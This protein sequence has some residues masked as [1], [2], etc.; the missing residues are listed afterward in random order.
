L[1]RARGDLVAGRP[2]GCRCRDRPELAG[3]LPSRDLVG[4]SRAAARH[5]DRL[6]R[7][8]GVEDAGAVPAPCRLPGHR[9][10]G[11]GHP[12]AGARRRAGRYVRE[13]ARRG[14]RCAPV[15]AMGLFACGAAATDG[16]L[17]RASI[18]RRRSAARQPR[19]SRVLH[20]LSAPH[21]GRLPRAVGR[22][23]R[24]RARPVVRAR[25]APLRH[26][27]RS[28]VHGG[29]RSRADA[30]GRDPHARARSAFRV[31]DADRSARSRAPRR[32]SF[33]RIAR[34]ELR[35]RVRVGRHPEE[36]RPPADAGG[37][38]AADHP[39]L[40]RAG[41]RHRGVIRA[42]VSARHVGI[43]RRDHRLLDRSR[44]HGG[45]VQ[46]ADAVSRDAA[47]EPAR[48]ARLRAGLGE[49]RRVHAHLRASV[50][51][52]RGAALPARRRLQPVLRPPV[53]AGGLD[54]R[55]GGA[56]APGGAAHGRARGAA[57]RAR[58]TVDHAEG[59]HMLTA[60][61]RY[62]PRTIPETDAIVAH[63]R[64][65]GTLIQGPDI[66][67]FER[68][69]AD[70]LGVRDVITTSYGRMAFYY[71]L[72]AFGFPAGAEVIV[73]ALTFWVIPEMV[74][75]AGLTP[76]PADVDP[77][78]FNLDA[79]AFERA[80]TSR[81]VAV[82]PTHLYGLPCDM[83]AI[84]AIAERHGLAVVEDC[85]HALGARHFGRQVGTFGDAAFF[86]FQTLKPLNTYG[87]GAAIVRDPALR[88]RVRAHAQAEPWPSEQ[89]VNNRLKLGKAQ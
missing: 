20:L 87:G 59:R 4:G 21:P 52:R 81:T 36:G 62:G 53:V 26:L 23:H 65:R 5:P 42:G 39:A 49:V 29:S 50:A 13:R 67:R 57:S 47:V 7:T 75:V 71:I 34:D 76:V 40:P 82:V 10:A 85:A 38:A 63:C 72:K 66:S 54:A 2:A 55:V 27:S 35:G 68:A 18:R 79:R 30:G 48:A 8:G 9:R 77:R 32:A 69:M 64:R 14:S 41:H 11:I 86:S 89:R 1:L 24:R 88:A 46:A 83:D 43:D 73:P 6:R 56:G 70:R 17:C 84:L 15:S 58:G 74:R 80:I 44:I 22:Q 28:A 78:T 25:R 19:L 33:R 37:A 31:R 51:D 3:G 16:S 61:C 45:A 12:L 60:I